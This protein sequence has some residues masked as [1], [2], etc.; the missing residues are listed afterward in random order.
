MTKDEFSRLARTG[1]GWDLCFLPGHLKAVTAWLGYDL[2]TIP[3][4]DVVSVM[5]PEN[6][7]GLEWN[8]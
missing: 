7:K 2:G 8:T 4:D 5:T 3:R 1:E 6:M